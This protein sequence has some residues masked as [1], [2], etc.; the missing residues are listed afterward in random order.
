MT[1]LKAVV[2][3]WRR[4][5][6]G[7]VV[8]LEEHSIGVEEAEKSKDEGMRCLWVVRRKCAEAKTEVPRLG[9]LVQAQKVMTCEVE[10]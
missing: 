8:A 4:N 7:S 10:F 1:V 5:L 3:D 2:D 6:V 9:V